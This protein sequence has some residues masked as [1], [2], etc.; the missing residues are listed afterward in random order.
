MFNNFSILKQNPIVP[1]YANLISGQS[2]PTE[3]TSSPQVGMEAAEA[4]AQASTQER[5]SLNSCILG[6]GDL[7]VVKN[8]TQLFYNLSYL[9]VS[10]GRSNTEVE[11]SQGQFGL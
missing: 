2:S 11:F 7:R 10:V 4:K 6:C 1:I 8:V 9:G 3:S 5:V